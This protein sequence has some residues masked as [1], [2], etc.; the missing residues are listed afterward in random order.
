MRDYI[1]VCD[2][3]DGHLLALKWTFSQVTG[4]WDV[5]NLGTGK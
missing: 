5:W 1:D 2:L 4:K 3:I